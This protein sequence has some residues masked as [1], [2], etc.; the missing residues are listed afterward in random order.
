MS[1]AT[2]EIVDSGFY[3]EPHGD[4]MDLENAG[5][6]LHP[7]GMAGVRPTHVNVQDGIGELLEILGDLFRSRI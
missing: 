7:F 5:A 1:D 4:H 2:V 3:L 6:S